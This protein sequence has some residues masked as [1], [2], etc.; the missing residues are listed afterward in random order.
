M[1]ISDPSKMEEQHG[2]KRTIEELYPGTYDTEPIYMTIIDCCDNHDDVYENDIHCDDDCMKNI[3]DNEHKK[4]TEYQ[5]EQEMYDYIAN[6]TPKNTVIT[7]LP[8]PLSATPL[9]LTRTITSYMKTTAL[10]AVN[11]PMKRLLS[12]AILMVKNKKSNS[13]LLGATRLA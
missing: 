6:M 1:D 8:E 5:I 12:I 7:A 11:L 10:T 9:H 4:L 13:W 2:R 3:H